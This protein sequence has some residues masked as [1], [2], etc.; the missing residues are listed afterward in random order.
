M[1]SCLLA[2]ANSNGRALANQ[3]PQI[4][5]IIFESLGG[6]LHP[7]QVGKEIPSWQN[8][9]RLLYKHSIAIELSL[10]YSLVDSSKKAK[11]CKAVKKYEFEFEYFINQLINLLVKPT[12]T[13]GPKACPEIAGP[14]Q[15][16]V[17]L[18]APVPADSTLGKIAASR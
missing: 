17:L 5:A 11:W 9:N 7:L 4:A 6:K 13:Q 10:I 15:C 12:P 14:S 3:L 1:L 8:L 16:F 2:T 18:R